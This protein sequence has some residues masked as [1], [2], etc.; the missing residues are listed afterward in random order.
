MAKITYT[1]A[2]DTPKPNLM[3]QLMMD[4]LTQLFG[5]TSAK[6][7]HMRAFALQKE[8]LAQL[9][10]N[11]SPIVWRHITKNIVPVVALYRAMEESGMPSDQAQAHVAGCMHRVVAKHSKKMARMAK[12]PFF[13]AMFRMQ[14]PSFMKK[15]Y[16]VEGWDMR[17]KRADKEEMAF[18][19]HRCIYLDVT[20]RLGCPELCI[21]F[22]ENDDISYGGM[23]PNIRFVRTQTLAGGGTCCDFRMLNG[24]YSRNT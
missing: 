22:C 17:W 12:M 7:Y 13:Y 4:E 9:S 19:C 10:D 11:G 5:Q 2:E 3:L 8:Y 6:A 23:A 24:R 21:A 20:T 14:A 1:T 15:N 18:D 16:P